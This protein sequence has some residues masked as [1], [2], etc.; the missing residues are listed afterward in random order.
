MVQKKRVMAENKVKIDK[1]SNLKEDI[2]SSSKEGFSNSSMNTIEKD[3]DKTFTQAKKEEKVLFH[4][5]K[6]LR[7]KN[8]VLF[9][10]VMAVGVVF[11]WRGIWNLIDRYWFTNL[12]QDFSDISGVLIG[13]IILYFADRLITHFAGE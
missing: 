7:K 10:V 13:L 8:Q 1:N 6:H 4:H 9:S 2:I 5:F 11:V 12:N 3:F